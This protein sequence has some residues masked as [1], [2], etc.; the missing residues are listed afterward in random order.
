LKQRRLAAKLTSP[1]IRIVAVAGIV[2]ISARLE[3]ARNSGCGNE[4]KEKIGNVEARPE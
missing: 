3:G 4:R 1:L 2:M